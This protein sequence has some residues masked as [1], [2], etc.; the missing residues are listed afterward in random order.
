[1]RGSD[2]RAGELFAYVDLERR[3]PAEH[4]LRVIR[5]VV[6]AALCELSGT[7]GQLYARLGR[8][9]VP[10]EKLLRALLLQAF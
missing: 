4:P 9:G 5:A 10:P 6:D 7:F 8:P 3:V 1:M 2:G